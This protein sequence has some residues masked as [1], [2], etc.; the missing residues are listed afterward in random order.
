[1]ASLTDSLPNASFVVFD[2]EINDVFKWKKGEQKKIERKCAG[3]T[4]FDC[5]VD[6]I[7]KE[8]KEKF[9]GLVMITDG[10]AQKPKLPVPS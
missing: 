5:V 2:T 9:D 7:E 10:E 1:M 8:S 6:Y 3:G 4:S